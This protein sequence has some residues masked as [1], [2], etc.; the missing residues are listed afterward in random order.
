MSPPIPK[1]ATCRRLHALGSLP[2]LFILDTLFQAASLLLKVIQC[3]KGNVAVGDSR[4]RLRIAHK[5]LCCASVSSGSDR[6]HVVWWHHI[7]AVEKRLVD[8]STGPCVVGSYFACEQQ[9]GSRS[10]VLNR[11]KLVAPPRVLKGLQ[12]TAVCIFISVLQ[13]GYF[14]DFPCVLQFM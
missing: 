12:D 14:L 9:L 8:C 4:A 10:T 6:G 11:V 1:R 5:W 13:W 2:A 7:T 3:P